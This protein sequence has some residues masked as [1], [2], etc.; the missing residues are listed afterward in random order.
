MH[1]QVIIIR[2][3]LKLPKGKACAQAA[4]ASI[5]AAHKAHK[6]D[7]KA[8]RTEGMAKIVVKTDNLEELYKHI[9]EAKNAGLPTSTITDAGKTTVEPGTTTCGAIGPAKEETIDQITGKLKLL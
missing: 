4:H 1:K 3:D 5:D 6:E 8:W 2:A 7:Y 9:Q